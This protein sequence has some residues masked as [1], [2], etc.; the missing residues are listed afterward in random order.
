MMQRHWSRRLNFI[1][2]LRL[3]RLIHLSACA[4]RGNLYGDACLI[5]MGRHNCVFSRGAVS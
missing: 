3:R 2:T 4:G 5:V 1:Q